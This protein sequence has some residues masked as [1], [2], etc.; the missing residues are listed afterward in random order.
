MRGALSGYRILDM[1]RVL[2]GP[3]ATQ[4][5]ADLGAEV[6]K[7]ERIDTGDS[8]RKFGPFFKSEDGQSKLASYFASANR[9]KKS[10]AIDFSRPEATDVVRSLACKCDVLIE[11]YKVGDLARFGLDYPELS[12]IHPGLVYCSITGFGQTGPYRYR[13]AYDLILQGMSGLMSITGPREDEPG[14]SPYRTGVA[15]SD[16][17]TGLYAATSVL[18]ALL[19]RERRGEGQ[20]IDLS[21]LEVQM[22]LLANVAQGYLASGE[23]PERHGN[24]HPTITPNQT[25]RCRDGYINIVAGSTGGQFQ[26]LCDALGCPELKTDS[27]FMD[28]PSRTRHRDI[29]IPLLEARL[30]EQDRAYWV[31]KLEPLGVPCG[32][33]NRVSEVFDDPQVRAR[34]VVQTM[35]HPKAGAMSFVRNPIRFSKTPPQHGLPP[36]LGEH[37]KEILRELAGLNDQQIEHLIEIGLVQ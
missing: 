15:M 26:K 3:W 1:T 5:F 8:T 4:L 11:N 32:T 22:A 31:S 13:A 6:I 30:M 23:E 12:K 19:H 36:D 10:L 37:S 9:G 18:A 20:H 24:R 17:N 35:Q 21:L 14:S 29:L 27:R 7:I 25:C 16:L 28:N 2:A 33:V 34:E